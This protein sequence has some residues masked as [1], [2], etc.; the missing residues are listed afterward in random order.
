MI[1]DLNFLRWNRLQNAG[2]AL[3]AVALLLGCGSSDKGK[4]SGT[5]KY[6]GQPVTGGSISFAP[7]LDPA[8]SSAGRVA[9]GAVRSD[10]GFTLSTDADEDGALIGRHEVIYSPPAVGGESAD[11]A[12]AK[13]PYDGLVPREPQV[14][15]K[16]GENSF[17]IEL[18]KAKPSP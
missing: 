16:G 14:E 7:V 12:V 6:E 18:V 1:R 5:V 10:G 17:A 9:T 8:K 13:S 11:P 15:V 2:F 3:A 4:V